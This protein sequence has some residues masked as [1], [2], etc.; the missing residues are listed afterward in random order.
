MRQSTAA[1]LASAVLALTVTG[2]GPAAK[3]APAKLT[4]TGDMTV[5]A[6]GEGTPG[7]PCTAERSSGID[8]LNLGA[9]VVVR[10]SSG[11]TVGLSSLGAGVFAI[12]PGG[13]GGYSVYCAFPFSVT[14]VPA[15]DHFYSIEVAHRGQVT[16]SQK[17]VVAPIHL[18]LHGG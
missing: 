12:E 3:A 1:I 7:K 8:D 11:K 16:L 4:L 18:N 15:G 6:S 10:D 9:P 2:C 17:N 13:V 14:A 5:N